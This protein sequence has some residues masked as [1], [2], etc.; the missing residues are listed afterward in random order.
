MV[1]IRLLEETC[2]KYELVHVQARYLCQRDYRVS[3][4]FHIC[5]SCGFL[6]RN[7]GLNTKALGA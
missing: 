6:S 7:F 2:K 4:P 5:D 3:I 1:Q